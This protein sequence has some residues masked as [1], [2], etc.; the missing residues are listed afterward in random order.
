MP[1]KSLK[2][3]AVGVTASHLTLQEYLPL[4][5]EEK[6]REALVKALTE[7]IAVSETVQSFLPR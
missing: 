6:R 7:S 3:R 2:I 5:I 1:Q 4:L